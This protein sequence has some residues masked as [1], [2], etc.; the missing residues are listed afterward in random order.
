MTQA[1]SD[2]PQRRRAQ[3]HFARVISYREDANLMLE[4]YDRP[5]S[6]AALL[7]ESAKQSIN[8]VANLNGQNPGAV[9][10]KKAYLRN[11]ISLPPGNRFDLLRG[12][13]SAT[14]LHIHADRGHLTEEDFRESW[15]ITQT[16]IE[17][18]LAIYDNVE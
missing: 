18:A 6:A 2:D 4:I 16:F 11:L 10:A 8:A 13:E 1:N 3:F 17:D 5:Y 7:Y 12:W 9:G 14:Q 15:Q